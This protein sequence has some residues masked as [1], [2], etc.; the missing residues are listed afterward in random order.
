MNEFTEM[1]VCQIL[2]RNESHLHTKLRENFAIRAMS[3]FCVKFNVEFNRQAVKFSTEF[4]E[5]T[6][7]P[8]TVCKYLHWFQRYLCLKDV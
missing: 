8:F 6:K 7:M 4:Y 3:I 5:R 1:N 2:N